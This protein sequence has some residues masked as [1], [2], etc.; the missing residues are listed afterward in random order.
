MKRIL[1]VSLL[2]LIPTKRVEGSAFAWEL[3]VFTNT[4]GVQIEAALLFEPLAPR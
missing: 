3:G 1:Q 4:S 2:L